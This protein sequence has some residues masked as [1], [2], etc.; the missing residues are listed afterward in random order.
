MAT[1]R[2]RRRD[3]KVQNGDYCSREYCT[4]PS[5]RTWANNTDSAAA[6]TTTEEQKRENQLG[7]T[8]LQ[9]RTSGGGGG[10]C[11]GRSWARARAG[12]RSWARGRSCG[13]CHSDEER[14]R[15]RNGECATG[16]CDRRATFAIPPTGARRGAA[17]HRSHFREMETRNKLKPRGPQ[18][19]SK[20][21]PPAESIVKDTQ[22]R[23]RRV[24]LH[25]S[26][27]GQAGHG[28]PLDWAPKFKSAAGR[29]LF[30]FTGQPCQII[31][32]SMLFGPK[33]LHRR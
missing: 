30:K 2:D 8:V 6:R 12:G 5:V 17:D 18:S 33:L 28:Q 27:E 9:D 20:F 10:R 31:P 3:E 22:L 26:C 25:S 7:K 23:R 15:K 32:N 13:K 21:L 16:Q 24:G 19:S 11:R 1:S 29:H 14:E 4:S